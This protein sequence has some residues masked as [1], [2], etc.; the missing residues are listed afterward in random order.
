[1]VAAAPEASSVPE[2]VSIR[3]LLP[4]GS[5]DDEA[6]DSEEQ[7][8]VAA[9][10]AMERATRASAEGERSL[11]MRERDLVREMAALADA[12]RHAPDSRV[13]ALVDCPNSTGRRNTDGKR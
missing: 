1:M 13:R 9:A 3:E 12:H 11:L 2:Q 7:R 8:E 5:D 4:A 6:E 10:D